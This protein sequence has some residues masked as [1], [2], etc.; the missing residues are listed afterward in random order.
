MIGVYLA[1]ALVSA[2]LESAESATVSR[3]SHQTARPQVQA[4]SQG[5]PSASTSRAILDR[6]CVTCHN[7]RLRTGNLA[8][9]TV[10]VD[11]V[12]DDA[13]VW[14][15]VLR[16]VRT[17]TFPILTAQSRYHPTRVHVPRGHKIVACAASR[18]LSR[19]RGLPEPTTG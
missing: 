11:H 5:A 9:E 19:R 18:S 6:Y 8:L 14:E 3:E 1:L 10:S 12:G 16:K 13:D 7:E 4:S 17:P 15:K 2:T